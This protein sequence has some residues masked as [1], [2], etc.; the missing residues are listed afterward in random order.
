MKNIKKIFLGSLAKLRFEF[1]WLKVKM[2]NNLQ[3]MLM[4]C[5]FR[6]DEVGEQ[7]YSENWNN[8]VTCLGNRKK[9]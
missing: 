8:L 6:F 9:V 5:S 7:A 4:I 2:I 3:Q 1:K